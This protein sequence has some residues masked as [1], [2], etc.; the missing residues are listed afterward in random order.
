MSL[1]TILKIGKAL[2]KAENNL[3]YFKYVEPYPTKKDKDGNIIYPLC[4][5]IPVKDD[6]SFDWDNVKVTPE[7]ERSN[8]YYLKF[9]TSDSDGLVKYVFGD[10]FYSKIAK[11]KKDDSIEKGENGFYRLENTGHS[12]AAYRLSSFNRG[13]KD[14]EEIYKSSSL[15][16]DLAVGQKFHN[17]LDKDLILVERILEYIPAIE[18]Y[19]NGKNNLPFKQLLD[20]ENLLKEY[21][22]VYIYENSGTVNLKKLIGSVKINELNENQKKKLLS[23]INGSVFIHFSF[24]MGKHWYQFEDDL[25]LTN[26]KILSDFVEKSANG[27][28]LKKTLYKTLCSG[29]KKN[30]IQFPFF[31]IDNKHKSMTFNNE[32]IQDL[33][34][35]IDYANKGRLI[36]GTDIK[37][38]TLPLGE[39]LKAN[40]YEDFLVKKDE[41]RIVA[42]N[43]TK[44]GQKDEPLFDFFSE[45]EETSIT[46]FDIIFC[47]KGGLTAPDT[48][49]IEISGIEKSN[50]RQT[51]KRITDI[52]SDIYMERK[53]YLRTEKDLSPLSIEF[54]F[55]N[56][57][58]T[59]QT[60][61]K[62]GKVTI[63]PNP[64]YQSHLLKVLPLIYTENYY[65]DDV[66]LPVFIQNIEYS[67]RAGDEKYSF[68]KF[69][70]K[71]LLKIQ[72][73]QNDKF[74]EISNSESYQIGLMLGSLARNLALE[75]NSFE[76][77]YV[78]NLT[79]RINN[80]PDFRKLKNEIEQKLIMH[81]KVKF[82]FQTS[83]DLAQ[84][85]KNFKGKY[86]K[87]ECAF[88]FLENYF[89][90]IAKKNQ[91][92]LETNS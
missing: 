55:R 66:L 69:D 81:D 71:F 26:A 18:Y 37:M 61:N 33:F 13:R 44:G 86:D 7:N 14:Y 29:D 54:S 27:L 49:L 45:K 36:S 62:T 12:N 79:R 21:S 82:T 43:K 19:F 64:K 58:G 11:I 32:D 56:I 1:D 46:S 6:F 31:E 51:K 35:A 77:N 42:I 85:V 72:N 2:R 84:N 3:K 17:T 70:L 25:N 28:V 24:P 9:K 88:G 5:T 67:I 75:I 41:G 57:L 63:K 65:Q 52:A 74:M 8:L 16:D 39:N 73:T 4:L 30:D 53:K 90:P 10:I 47:K 34:Y 80:L 48:D 40:D 59:P 68:L 91:P 76:K 83:Y 23:F 15:E 92:V 38:I 60:D 50:L 89:K 20:D 22:I 87:D 78:G